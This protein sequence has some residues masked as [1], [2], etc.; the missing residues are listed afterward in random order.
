MCYLAALDGVGG[1]TFS[2]AAARGRVRAVSR[3][4]PLRFASSSMIDRAW[5]ASPLRASESAR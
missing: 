1:G 5:A 2:Q 4:L 3:S